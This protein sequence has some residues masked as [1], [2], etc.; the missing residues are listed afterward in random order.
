MYVVGGTVF[1]LLQLT[2]S[3]RE[4]NLK[5]IRFLQVGCCLHG[6]SDPSVLSRWHRDWNSLCHHR[7]W[8][9]AFFKIWFNVRYFRV[10]ALMTLGWIPGCLLSQPESRAKPTNPELSTLWKRSL[11]QMALNLAESSKR[12]PSNPRFHND[13]NI[14][15]ALI[16]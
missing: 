8:I 11:T 5:Y 4:A 6:R 7:R 12:T 16:N 15:K 10:S 3:A 1:K 2:S 14:A 13:I 9:N